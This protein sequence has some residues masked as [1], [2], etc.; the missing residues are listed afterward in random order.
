MTRSHRLDTKLIHSGEAAP[1]IEGAVTFPIFQ[2][3]MFETAGGEGYHDVRYIRLNNTPNHDVLHAKLADLEN[4][5]AALVTASGMAAIATTLLTFLKP[6][7]HVIAQTGL[8]GGTQTLFSGDFAEMGIDVDL[9]DGADPGSWESKLR[10]QTRVMYV[11]AIA[12][13][14]MTVTDLEA[15]V[16]FARAHNLVSMIDNTFATPVNYRPIDAGFDLSLHSG[17]KYLN[18]HNDIVAGAVIGSA[19]K[20]EKVRHKLNHLGGSLDP[21]ACFLLHRGLKTLGVRVRA[22]NANALEVARF[23]DEHPAVGQVNYPGLPSNPHHE[24]AKRFFDGFGGMLSFELTGGADAARRFLG[25]V[26]LPRVAPSLGG[27]ESLVTMP[28]LT[29]HVGM[30]AEQRRAAGIGDGLVRMSV[31]IESTDDL[32]DDLRSA[33]ES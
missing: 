29:S 8:Y 16:A 14:T 11:E 19:E 31:G 7:D 1:G 15:A 21:H 33:I 20:V 23:L 13:P 9:V 5:E 26:T 2:T 3:A 4:A 28:A 12:N 17:T 24:R 25:K 10:P 32:I 30:T 6:G 22:Q 18:G 27:V